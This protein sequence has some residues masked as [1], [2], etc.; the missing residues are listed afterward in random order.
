MF[1]NEADIFIPERHRQDLLIWCIWLG[2][3]NCGLSGSHVSRYMFAVK[4]YGTYRLKTVLA[5]S[6]TFR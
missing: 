6:C 5:R 4:E 2:K 1:S 3:L